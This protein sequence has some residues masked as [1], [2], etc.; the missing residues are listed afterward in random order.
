V[1]AIERAPAPWN[2][3]A[4]ARMEDV[5][6]SHFGRDFEAAVAGLRYEGWKQ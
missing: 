1:R 5:D 2:L 4:I 3:S 6:Y